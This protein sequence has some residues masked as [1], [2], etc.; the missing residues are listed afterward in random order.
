VNHTVAI[1][2][3]DNNSAPLFDPE[4]VAN[5]PLFHPFDV[6]PNNETHY[7][8]SNTLS[9]TQQ[10]MSS[11]CESTLP[12]Y[13]TMS[14]ES[15]AENK[16][17]HQVTTCQSSNALSAQQ[18]C[19]SFNSL[20]N[21]QW[22]PSQTTNTAIPDEKQVT[23]VPFLETQEY[24][25]ESY[26]PLSS[27]AYLSYPNAPPHSD[28]IIESQSSDDTLKQMHYSAQCG[29][30]AT[31]LYQPVTYFSSQ[32]HLYPST[33]SVTDPLYDPYSCMIMQQNN[34][35]SQV[36]S[37]NA[38]SNQPDTSAV[39]HSIALSTTNLEDSSSKTPETKSGKSSE[40]FS[41]NSNEKLPS[42]EKMPC[43]NKYKWNK[44]NYCKFCGKAIVKIPRHLL[45]A[46]TD[47]KEVQILA[48]MEKD[49]RKRKTIMEKLRN[50]GNFLHNKTVIENGEGTLMPQRRPSSN[51]QS[52]SHYLPCYH[53]KGYFRKKILWQHEKRCIL[54][55]EVTSH[56]RRVIV[57]SQ[58]M[59]DGID[60]SLDGPFVVKVVHGMMADAITKACRNDDLIMRFGKSLHTKVHRAHSIN[61]IRQRMRQ[62]GRLLLELKNMDRDINELKDAVSVTK[63][64]VILQA[65]KNVC[66][67]EEETQQF[68]IPGLALKYGHSLR[69]CAMVL[70][71]IAMRTQNEHLSNCIKEFNTLMN[72]EWTE[73]ISSHAIDTLDENK[74]NNP[75][76]LPLVRDV[77]KM[78]EFVSTN[79]RSSID[80][81]RRGNISAYSNVCRLAL[82]SLILFNRRRSGEAQRMTIENYE[83][84]SASSLNEDITNELSVIEQMLLKFLKR[85]EIRGKRGRRVPLLMRPVHCE[86]INLLLEKR[87]E[88]KIPQE[89]TYIF[90]RLQFSSDKPLDACEVMRTTADN[91]GLERPELLRSTKLRKQIGTL[92]QLLNLTQLELEQLCTFMGHNFHVN[93]YIYN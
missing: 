63:F 87:S 88:L 37:S 82:A 23:N 48:A 16:Q 26:N 89:N 52:V 56:G 57:R 6:A 45:K 53:C 11:Y 36:N 41:M 22:S 73:C 55:N 9:V 5:D 43:T 1:S 64:D 19:E 67:F 90:P 74:F 62:L 7:H 13:M 3:S 80:Q 21:I 77:K 47:Q 86:A 15:N 33:Q 42:V 4:Q 83:K 2:I 84:G 91:A 78:T 72:N 44:K 65:V 14:S 12:D 24:S 34:C 93:M 18:H 17:E 10:G 81:L 29:P 76:V 51:V 40:L 49:D 58:M 28:Q 8:T 68:K 46:H 38:G 61:Y 92:S 75:E 70:E 59:I 27:L 54:N 35:S 32:Q 20:S 69:K 30:H 60:N 66:A 71:G 79:L 31:V 39:E 25:N 50:E 85:I